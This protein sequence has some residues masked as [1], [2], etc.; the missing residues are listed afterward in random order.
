MGFFGRFAAAAT[1]LCT[2]VISAGV[3]GGCTLPEDCKVGSVRCVGDEVQSCT[4]HGG[5]VYGGGKG[6]APVHYDKSSSPTW[7]HLE[8]CGAS[9]CISPP[10]T[11]A[12]A[13]HQAFCALEPKPRPACLASTSDQTCDGTSSLRCYDGYAVSTELCLACDVSKPNGLGDGCVGGVYAT[14][15][16]ST[17]CAPGLECNTNGRCVMPCACAEGAACASCDVLGAHTGQASPPATWVCQSGVCFE[18]Y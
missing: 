7:E 10:Q 11:D 12:A 2:L 14:C 4:A 6:L 3:T 15:K 16:A 9:R 13:P 17:D 8:T 1:A 18:R 5:G